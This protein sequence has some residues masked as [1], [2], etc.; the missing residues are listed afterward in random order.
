MFC[1]HCGSQVGDSQ[2]FCLVCGSNA[3]TR[4]PPAR[5]PN[6]QQEVRS[7]HQKL[8]FILILCG[9]L[10]LSGIVFVAGRESGGDSPN[11]VAA[12]PSVPTPPIQADPQQSVP[13]PPT[14][15]QNA[16][17]PAAPPPPFPEDEIDLISTVNWFQARYVAAANEFQK[18]TI[19]RER[20]AAIA[21]IFPSRY[22]SGWIGQI[23]T[24][25][26]TS[27]GRGILSLKLLRG[28]NISVETMNNG[29]SDIGSDTLIP[30][31]SPLYD[32]VSR[33][34]VGD[35]VVFSGTFAASNRDYIEEISVTEEGSMTEPDFIFT[36]ASVSKDY[37]K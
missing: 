8:R 36:F 34:A 17:N 24:M 25:Q 1:Q 13:T 30:A 12:Q 5:G 23:A 20:Q 19:R 29:F 3:F 7:N 6:P 16:P 10:T 11:Q 33:L 14:E 27:D 37:G 22:V 32:Q 21:A 26:T 15:E 9:L 28:A 4:T 31:G 2:T 18:S 35:E